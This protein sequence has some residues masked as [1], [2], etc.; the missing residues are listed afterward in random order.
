LVNFILHFFSLHS[1]FYIRFDHFTMR[2]IEN[3]LYG[4]I[5]FAWYEIIVLLKNYPNVRLTFDFAKNN[6]TFLSYKGLNIE[7]L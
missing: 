1:F 7:R 5:Q 3:G 2:L 6:S 4:L